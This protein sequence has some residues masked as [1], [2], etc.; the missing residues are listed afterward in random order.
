MLI[1]LCHPT[2]DRD[3][4]AVIDNGAT[5]VQEIGQRCGAG[6]G[7]GACVEDLRDRLNAKGVNGCPR[8]C[9]PDLV[10]L[11]STR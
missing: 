3:L 8:D 1:C 5:T 6:T 9:A 2:S 10:S 7:C 4:D 11:R